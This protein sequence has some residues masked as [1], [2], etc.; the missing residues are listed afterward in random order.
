MTPAIRSS[1]SSAPVR[2]NR[3]SSRAFPALDRYRSQQVRGLGRPLWQGQRAQVPR[4]HWLTDEEKLRICTFA[5]A[6]PLEGYRRMTFMMLD[7]DVVTC[8]PANV[9]RVLK[10]A[11][12]LGR[13]DSQPHAQGQRLRAAPASAS[14]VARGCQLPQ[15][16]RHVLLPLLDP[17]RLQPLDRP[18]GKAGTL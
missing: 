4:D 17:G 9:Y 15:H 10:K 2:E 12:L 13:L 3:D 6:H 1:T 11:E 16:R 8:S 5:R 7:A 18:L 14:G